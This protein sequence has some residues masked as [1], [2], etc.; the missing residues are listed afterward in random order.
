MEIM[1][2]LLGAVFGGAPASF[3]CWGALY[4]YGTV[5]LHGKGSLFD[6]NPDIADA[7]F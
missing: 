6:T 3:A 4:F 2:A 7:F 5:V 1:K